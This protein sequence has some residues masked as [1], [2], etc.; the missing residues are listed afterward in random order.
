MKGTTKILKA[1]CIV[2]P[3]INLFLLVLRWLSV[4][5][6]DKYLRFVPSE[7]AV[8]HLLE[9][10]FLDV[11]HFMIYTIVTWILMLV[12]FHLIKKDFQYENIK[13]RRESL[14]STETNEIHDL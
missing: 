7:Q 5:L 8:D 11:Y 1:V 6:D 4:M 10:N 3:I 12:T 14:P 13:N 9:C 2:L